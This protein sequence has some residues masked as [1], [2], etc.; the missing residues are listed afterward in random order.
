[1]RNDHYKFFLR[2]TNKKIYLILKK[3]VS[4]FDDKRKIGMRL[5]V[6][7]DEK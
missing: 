7:R 5:K 2:S 4:N 1:M 3:K 6:N